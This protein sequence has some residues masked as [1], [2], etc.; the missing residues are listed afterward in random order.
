MSHDSE[1][2]KYNTKMICYL[3]KSVI[4]GNIFINT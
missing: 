1:M 3:Y 4:I 2:K